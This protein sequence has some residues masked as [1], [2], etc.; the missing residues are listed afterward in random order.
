MKERWKPIDG[1]EG[2][3]EVSDMGRVK[4][5]SRIVRRGS[6]YM[7]IQGKI[8]EASSKPYPCVRLSS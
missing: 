5:L 4:S 8:L 3:Y 2:L 6:N 7:T 1:W